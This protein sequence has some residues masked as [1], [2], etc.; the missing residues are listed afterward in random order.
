VLESVAPVIEQREARA[1]TPIPR[2][3]EDVVPPRARDQL[4]RPQAMPP[5]EH[6][7][8]P[9]DAARGTDRP[10]PSVSP[11]LLAALLVVIAAAAT[12][13]V[14]KYVIQ[15]NDTA[16]QAAP[17]PAPTAAKP[18]QPP[19]VP[20][21]VESHKL[22]L[23]QPPPLEVKPTTA[24]Q[25]ESIVATETVHANDPVAYLVGH[26]Q[27]EEQIASFQKDIDGR[28][29]SA[30]GRAEKARDTANA[31]G[32]KANAAQWEKVIAERNK[33]VEDKQKTIE[34]KRGELDK[35]VLRAAA[36]G[37]LV[38]VAKVQ[39]RVTPDDVVARIERSPM[40]SAT[41]ASAA[42][43]TTNSAVL[44]VV[45][46]TDKKLSCKVTTVDAGGAH[47]ACPAAPASA[48]IEVTFG[49]PDPSAP[50]PAVDH[51]PGE[52][53][54]G[55]EIEMEGDQPAPAP[56]PAKKAPAAPTPPAPAP[57]PAPASEPTAGSAAS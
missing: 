44:L 54:K 11:L 23:E 34:T 21:L 16:E 57:A 5:V 36:D 24:G 56:A 39:T 53:G 3:F 19:Q 38:V 32:D 40:L 33:M 28:L 18:P 8:P 52:E 49:G 45:K 6:I 9:R 29:K 17:S 35:Y 15:R 25:L 50:P 55:E 43:A 31:A 47:V 7:A 48:G 14:Y 26:K 2:P 4:A 30:V 51:K 20:T 37:K 46:G 12:F 22:A 10:S 13:L 27:I 42:T 41:F 1:A